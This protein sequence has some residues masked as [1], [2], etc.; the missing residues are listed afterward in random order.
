ML[1]GEFIYTKKNYFL[2]N[3]SRFVLKLALLSTS[4]Q[5]EF[6]LKVKFFGEFGKKVKIQ[7]K[8]LQLT[9]LVCA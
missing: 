4:R 6:V 3:S 7:V 2:L 5:S 9:K 1:L 8:W